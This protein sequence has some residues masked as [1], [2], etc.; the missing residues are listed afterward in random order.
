MPF[1]RGDGKQGHR[2]LNKDGAVTKDGRRETEEKEIPSNII[3]EK[4][5]AK[6]HKLDGVASV[7]FASV[8][9]EFKDANDFV[10]GLK[11]L[12]RKR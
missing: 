3:G 4:F 6:L 8:Y 7:R 10:S 2:F 5:M 9:R 12:L 1:L 11:N